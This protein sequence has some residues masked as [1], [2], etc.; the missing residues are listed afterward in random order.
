MNTPP[1]PRNNLEVAGKFFEDA[2]DLAHR[3][4]LTFEHYYAIKSRRLKCFID[5]RWSYEC[6]LKAIIAYRQPREMER[7]ALIRIA[8]KARH[9]ISA[10]EEA[11]LCDD[12]AFDVQARGHEIDNLPVGLRYALDGYDFREAKI[13]LYYQTIGSDRWMEDFYE[14]LIRLID[15]VDRKLRTRAAVVSMAD[16]PIDELLKVQFNK[17]QNRG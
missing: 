17:F 2:L 8:E 15:Q 5:L 3:F 7:E 14:Y 10:L 13:D 4:N 16:I 9:N 12:G 6:I 1:Y 11:A